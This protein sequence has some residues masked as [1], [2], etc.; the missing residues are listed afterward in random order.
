MSGLIAGYE[1]I[2]TGRHRV[3][4]LHAHL[5]VMT[6]YRHRVFDERHLEPLE[7]IMRN[8]CAGFEV[9]LEE[10]NGEP[11]HVHL[12]VNFPAAGSVGGAPIFVLHQ[13]VD[14]Q[15]QPA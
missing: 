2:R 12:L 5:V 13:Y 11:N 6:R 9:T 14:Q 15:N 3:F 1:D 8:I 7:E 10:F 4:I